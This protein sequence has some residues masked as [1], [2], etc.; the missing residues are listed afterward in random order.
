MW[1][2]YV[3]YVHS[4]WIGRVWG[5][6]KD[7][8]YSLSGLLVFEYAITEFCLFSPRWLLSYTQGYAHHFENGYS[9]LHHWRRY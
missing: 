8:Y 7:V 6:D 9:A 1:E 2:Y 4:T 3:N 5:S